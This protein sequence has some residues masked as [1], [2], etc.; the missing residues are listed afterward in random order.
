MAQPIST[1]LQKVTTTSP[2]TRTPATSGFGQRSDEWAQLLFATQQREWTSLVVVPAAAG[3]ASTM[4]VASPLA[5][6]MRLYS[7]SNVHLFNGF[8]ADH[9]IAIEI[10]AG[11][12]AASACGESS[13]VAVSFPMTNAAAIH[14][15][16]AA[17]AA[18][19]VVPLGVTHIEG[20]RHVI[21]AIGRDRVIGSLTV[22]AGEGFKRSAR[23]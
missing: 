6:V 21:D 4:T 11:M 7:T 3:G 17:D 13:I 8:G 23:T 20:A 22:R 19:L 1:E 14:I 9:V 18:L 16:R 2:T 10:V 12:R 15:A 5:D